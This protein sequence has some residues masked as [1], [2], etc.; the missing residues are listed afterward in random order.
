MDYKEVWERFRE[1]KLKAGRSVRFTLHDYWDA[2]SQLFRAYPDLKNLE[3]FTAEKIERWLLNLHVSQ[4]SKAIRRKQINVFFNWCSKLAR[5]TN[6]LTSH[7]APNSR[8]AIT[9]RL[10]FE[11]R[12]FIKGKIIP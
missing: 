5:S 4:R 11:R 1:V 2:L 7:T 6:T 8:V 10:G 9:S 12:S 3:D